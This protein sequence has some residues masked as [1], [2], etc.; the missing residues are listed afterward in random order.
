MEPENRLSAL[1]AKTES[2]EQRTGLQTAERIAYWLDDALRIPFTNFRIGLDPILGLV[3]GLGDT[4]T[5]LLSV[6]L[7]GTAVYYRLPKTVLLRMAFNVAGDYL[8]GLIP[9]LGDASDFIV[10]SNRRNLRLLR[11]YANERTEPR[12]S[13]YLF[14]GLLLVGLLA[15]I[16]GGIAFTYFVASRLLRSLW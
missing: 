2:G 11:Q 7:I 5:A 9:Y 8:L 13:D 4:L 12:L 6:Y 10:K 16:M 14:V 1:P 15:L 3:P